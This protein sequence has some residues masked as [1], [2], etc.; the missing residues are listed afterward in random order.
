MTPLKLQLERILMGANASTDL[1]GP[2]ADWLATELQKVYDQ[3]PAKRGI[4]ARVNG[5]GD[6]EIDNPKGGVKVLKVDGKQWVLA[7]S[8]TPGGGVVQTP[9]P[10]ATVLV[11]P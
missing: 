10:I 3:D 2:N 9:G 11:D 4:T 6:V 5:N 1:H 7:A 8:A